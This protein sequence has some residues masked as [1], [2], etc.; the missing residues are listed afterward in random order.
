MILEKLAMIK[1]YIIL[2]EIA[3]TIAA[4]EARKLPP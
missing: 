2:Q 3:T 4:I 1:S